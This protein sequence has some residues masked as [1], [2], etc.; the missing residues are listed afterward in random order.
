MKATLS[1]AD[2]NCT[3]YVQIEGQMIII[4][5][6]SGGPYKIEVNGHYQW[7]GILIVS[8]SLQYISSANLNTVNSSSII[9]FNEDIP[10]RHLTFSDEFKGYLVGMSSKFIDSLST[11]MSITSVWDWF[12]NGALVKQMTK[13]EFNSLR[14]FVLLMFDNIKHPVNILDSTATEE[15]NRLL[16]KALFCRLQSKLSKFHSDFQRSRKEQLTSEF[17]KLAYKYGATHR[18]L[19][20]YAEKL[21]VTSKYLSSI[22]TSIS[23]KNSSIWLEEATMKKAKY[24]LRETAIPIYQVADQ[25]NFPTPADFTRYFK[26]R[27]G[28]N[29]LRYRNLSL[30]DHL[31]HHDACLLRLISLPEAPPT[32]DRGSRP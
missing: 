30:S 8:G 4:S 1:K 25:L 6:P 14:G 16:S 3:E 7:W 26:N 23:G 24:L 10:L 21:C 9:L 31:P 2:I 17:I 19:D 13:E 28:I 12:T 20:F 29:P 18:D 22:V 27:E 32:E 11:D 5:N 15:I